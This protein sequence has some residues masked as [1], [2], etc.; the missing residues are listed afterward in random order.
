MSAVA[1]YN[2][3]MGLSPAR[4][5][6]TLPLFCNSSV[7]TMRSNNIYLSINFAKS[8]KS[9]SRPSF[10]NADRVLYVALL[11]DEIFVRIAMCAD[12]PYFTQYSNLSNRENFIEE[13][14][15][16]NCVR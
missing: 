10:L 4:D 12:I 9:T 14:P 13:E 6:P 8:I 3:N 1:D 5:T 2:L 15:N 11:L 16:Q 7:V